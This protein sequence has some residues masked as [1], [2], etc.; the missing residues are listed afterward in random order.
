MK[1]LLIC[2]SILLL[3]SGCQEEELDVIRPY[4][5][6]YSGIFTESENGCIFPGG[7]IANPEGYAITEYGI[8][9]GVPAFIQA[10]MAR[11]EIL[12][13]PASDQIEFSICGGLLNGSD[14][15]FRPYVVSEGFTIYGQTKEFVAENMADPFIES[16][17]ASEGSPGEVIELKGSSMGYLTYHYRVYF[18]LHQ[19]QPFEV[20]D[21]VMMFRV[22]DRISSQ[23][24]D[25]VLG[26]GDRTIPLNQTF[27]IME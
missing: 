9:Y 7:I 14:Y 15:I 17:S 23:A 11:I 12:E 18:D 20:R 10:P 2:L 3:L 26:I 27:Q 19:V 24:Y 25:L 22:P 16:I 13:A 21:S 5:E 1:N 6:I 8:E 4:P